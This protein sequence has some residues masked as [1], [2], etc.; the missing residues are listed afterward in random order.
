MA[1]QLIL[2][3]QSNKMLHNH[4]A[5]QVLV[6]GCLPKAEFVDAVALLKVGNE[7]DLMD[8]WVYLERKKENIRV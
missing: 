8:I 4:K 3:H 7:H 2:L 1:L 6:V 5:Q